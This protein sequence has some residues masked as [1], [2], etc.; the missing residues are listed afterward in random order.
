M[1]YSTQVNNYF[2]QLMNYYSNQNA[3]TGTVQPTMPI[4]AKVLGF[5]T[6]VVGI[7]F[8]IL[9]ILGLIIKP[10]FGALADRVSLF[11]FRN[12]NSQIFILVQMASNYPNY[13]GNPNNHRL[14]RNLVYT[15]CAS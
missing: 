1:F 6:F 9:P 12:L 7:I 13:H 14:L 4:Y 3:G 2:F 11:N 8:T 10:A 15:T 5:S